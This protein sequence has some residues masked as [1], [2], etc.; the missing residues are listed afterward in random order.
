MTSDE[1]TAVPG[2]Q[3]PATSAA[4]SRDK[5]IASMIPTDKESLFNFRLDWE[6]IEKFGI[7]E[8]KIRSWVT[9]KIEE[10]LGENEVT[11]CSFIMGKLATRSSPKDLLGTYYTHT[12]YDLLL[13]H[14][15]YNVF[16]GT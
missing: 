2:Q 5:E 13:A 15:L 7:L 6:A 9:K 3:H 8:N 1:S 4:P 16:R 10:Y 11:L 14:F 12:L